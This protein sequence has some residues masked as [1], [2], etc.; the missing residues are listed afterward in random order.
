L[1]FIAATEDE[2]IRA[3]DKNTG[4]L[5]RQTK[6]PASGHA[7]P[8]VYEFKGKQFIVIACGGEKGSKSG[9]VYM[10]FSLP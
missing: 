4:A 8:A 2:M 6:L 10:A 1:V 9:D 7:T 5:L 3:F